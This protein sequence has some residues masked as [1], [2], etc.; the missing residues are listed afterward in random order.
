MIVVDNG[1]TDGSSEFIKQHHPRL[2][3]IKSPVNNYCH[4]NNLAIKQAKGKY[5]GLINND[6]KLNKDW[7]S[8]LLKVIDSN[9]R[10]GA[11]TGKI[12]FPNKRINSTGHIE[13]PNL[14][15]ADR[16]FK[17]KDRGQYNK[18]E[19]IQSL[20]HCACLYRKEALKDAGPLD[21]DFNMY[22]EDIDMSIRLRQKGWQLYYVPGAICYHKFHGTAEDDLVE[23][24]CERSRLIFIAKHH[25]EK[26]GEHLFGKG[27]FTAINERV[28]RQDLYELLSEVFSKI[29][30]EHNFEVISNVL[31]SVWKDLKKILAVEQQ[32]LIKRLDR[33]KDNIKE[34]DKQILNISQEIQQRLD[35]L[36]QRKKEI[37]HMATVLIEK[38]K[39][40]LNRDEQIKQKIDLLQ[41]RNAQLSGKDAE[42]VKRDRLLQEKAQQLLDKENDLRQKDGQYQDKDRQLTDKDKQLTDKENILKQRDI[43]LRQKDD[44]IIAKDKEVSDKVVFLAS[45]RQE[46]DKLSYESGKQIEEIKQNNEQLIQR[47]KNAERLIREM[48]VRIQAR[49]VEIRKLNEGISEFYSSETYRFIVRPIWNGLNFLKRL[50]RAFRLIRFNIVKLP[51][52]GLCLAYFSS[53]SNIAK[54]KDKNHYTVK[55]TNNTSTEQPLKIKVIIEHG[56][57][58]CGYFTKNIITSSESSL[59]MGIDYDWDNRAVFYLNGKSQEADEFWKRS[60]D[61]KGFYSLGAVLLDSEGKQIDRLNIFQ[62]LET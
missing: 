6:V 16:G 61:S 3:L 53:Q 50:L 5:I 15:W 49:D 47:E 34:K 30:K 45:L 2:K 44:L 8:E 52:R 28:Q 41:E 18:L 24:Y 25:P 17:E 19:Q 48:D 58:C 13:L 1:S 33:E 4:A 46:L 27:Y 42:L 38:D 59:E 35:E 40:I 43:E 56:N 20:S 11:V 29:L 26:I 14:Y 39:Q 54:P 62:K 23:H 55:L 37:E 31:P 12:L 57:V 21:E 22:L 36:K 51:K 9:P 32:Y 60:F 10:V 7:L